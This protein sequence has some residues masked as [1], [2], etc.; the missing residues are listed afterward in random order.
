MA[1]GQSARPKPTVDGPDAMNVITDPPSVEKLFN[2]TS[3]YATVKF[4]ELEKSATPYDQTLHQ[5]I[6][7]DQKQLAAR[8]VAE[9]SRRA[10]LT[11]EDVYFFGLLQ[12]LATNF[13]GA[14]ESF[15]KYLETGKT[16]PEKAQ[17]AR[18]L[19]TAGYTARR[20]M[21]DAEVY[22]AEY[23]KNT[24]VKSQDRTELEGMLARAYLEKKDYDHA[25][26]HAEEAY[27][28]VKI[29]FA[30]PATRPAEIYKIY[31]MATMLFSIYREKGDL[32]QA[33]ATLEDLQKLGAYHDSSD[34]YFSATDKIMTLMI[35]NGQKTEALARLKKIKDSIDQ[36][37]RS[38]GVKSEVR[39]LI[40]KRQLHYDLMG[41]KAPELN[42]DKWLSGKT[43]KLADLR[44]KVV[45]IDFWATW[46][47]PCIAAFPAL[48]RWQDKYRDQG[49]E[50]VGITR[51]Y[52]VVNGRN[53]DEP[54]ELSFLKAFVK[55]QR[56]PYDSIVAKE[57]DN[58]AYYGANTLPTAVLIDRKGIVRYITAG[59]NS[60]REDETLKMIETL[61]AE[62]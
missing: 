42:I 16:D 15:K 43:Q 26:P 29:Y 18:F 52:G 13:D 54:G 56:L 22:L 53:I 44:G 24:P 21:P 40:I 49:F 48:S 45:M 36:T 62:K 61:L 23:V 25:V 6:L 34:L 9:L 14:S 60:T 37:F 1:M 59:T 51:Y 41:E 12:N 35:D 19:L 17:R 38:A 20:V 57:N 7:R 55:T 2:E 30:E 11:G 4:K 8:Y 33:I 58:H 3:E 32:K 28:A 46:C 50:I 39:R 47:A 10:D 5:Q 31:Q 27:K